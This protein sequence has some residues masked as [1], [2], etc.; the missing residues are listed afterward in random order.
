MLDI[1]GLPKNANGFRTT[2]T[3]EL[4]GFE[5]KTKNKYREKQDHLVMKHFKERIDKIF[6]H[7]RPYACPNPECDFTGKD[8]QALL[9]H[10]TG[11]HGVLE[12]YLREALA[13]KGIQYQ[14]SDSAKRKSMG[15]SE[16]HQQSAAKRVKEARLSSCSSPPLTVLP[17]T[18]T[19]TTIPSMADHHANLLVDQQERQQQQGYGSSNSSSPLGSPLNTTTTTTAPNHP[20]QESSI[21]VVADTTTPLGPHDFNVIGGIGDYLFCTTAASPPPP[22]V[23]T[24]TTTSNPT[25]QP[26]RRLLPTMPTTKL[27]SMATVLTRSPSQTRCDVE[28]LLA[29][30]HPIETQLVFSLPASSQPLMAGG[31]RCGGGV[32]SDLDSHVVSSTTPDFFLPAMPSSSSSVLSDEQPGKLVLNDNIMWCGGSNTVLSESAQTVPVQYL[33]PADAGFVNIGD[34]DFD[35]LYPATVEPTPPP[36]NTLLTVGNSSSSNSNQQRQLSFSML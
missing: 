28:A 15:H 3:C 31:G 4:C 9:R 13:E 33:D 20:H 12:L 17:P 35:Y 2:H 18:T 19:N 14:L 11:K 36:V 29:S 22:P 34:V 24:A 23:T 5:P 27:P 32:V 8:K 26:I 16:H 10:Y 30:F 1:I 25:N 7:C 21:M 6:P